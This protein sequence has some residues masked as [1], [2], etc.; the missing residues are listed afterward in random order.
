MSD[1][2]TLT[3]TRAEADRL[4]EALA[5][6]LDGMVKHREDVRAARKLWPEKTADIFG[7]EALDETI[8][9]TEHLIEY[10]LDRLEEGR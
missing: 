9:E 1:Y 8:H 7:D 5:W 2:V 10:L 3:L 4:D 6:A